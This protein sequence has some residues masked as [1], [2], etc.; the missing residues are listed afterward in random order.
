LVG[1][2]TFFFLRDVR[3]IERGKRLIRDRGR[4]MG[5]PWGGG[6]PEERFMGGVERDWDSAGI[7]NF[8]NGER[9]PLSTKSTRRGYGGYSQGLINQNRE[10]KGS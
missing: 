2:L 10:E 4:V 3:I 1:V 9:K 7:K 8:V 6:F 5:L